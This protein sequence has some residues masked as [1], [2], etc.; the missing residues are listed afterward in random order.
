MAYED[1][2]LYEAS[3]PTKQPFQTP[4]TSLVRSKV[5]NMST[6][7]SEV[8]A[9]EWHQVLGLTDGSFSRQVAGL[10]TA[11]SEQFFYNPILCY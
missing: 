6:D 10:L 7:E 9:R 11:R 8:D 5:L 2:E 1:K 3:G 4:K